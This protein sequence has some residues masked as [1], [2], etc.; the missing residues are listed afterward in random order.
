VQRC[1][2]GTPENALVAK[3]S[4]GVTALSTAREQT[5]QQRR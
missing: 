4:H 2:A 5:F 1:D 3:L